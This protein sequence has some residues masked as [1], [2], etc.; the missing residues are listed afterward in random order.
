MK[1]C[2]KPIGQNFSDEF[3]NTVY[4]TFRPIGMKI[5]FIDL[6]W[7]YFHNVVNLSEFMD[8]F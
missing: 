5:I 6:F 1:S 2:S 4:K 3:S 7:K 8:M